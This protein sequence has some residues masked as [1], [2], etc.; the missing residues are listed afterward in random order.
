[1]RCLQLVS[2]LDARRVN[3]ISVGTP[4]V[5]ETV[6]N[7]LSFNNR[8]IFS[9]LPSN[10]KQQLL[11]DRDPH[12]NVQVAKIETEK[13]L[14][15]TVAAELEHLAKHGK[16]KGSFSPQFHSYGYEGRS[17]LPSPFDATYC[18]ALV[19]SLSRLFSPDHR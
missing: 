5:E 17:C 13:L 7:E 14:A 16:Y 6:I 11:L 12:G 1:M 10:I 19:L 3:H 2:F 9:Y 15:Q 4:P 8:A 18:Y